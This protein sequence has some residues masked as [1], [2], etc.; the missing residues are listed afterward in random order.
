M[1]SRARKK[2]VPV[3]VISREDR[4]LECEACAWRAKSAWIRTFEVTEWV[5]LSSDRD[6]T[7]R[8]PATYVNLPHLT[9]PGARLLQ[10]ASKCLARGSLLQAD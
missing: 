9:L 6:N 8:A 5:D 7:P 2:V 3:Q 4:S 10:R 1:S